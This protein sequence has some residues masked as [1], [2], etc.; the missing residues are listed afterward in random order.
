MTEFELSPQPL[1]RLCGADSIETALA[2]S[3]YAGGRLMIGSG[4]GALDFIK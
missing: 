2:R 3:R 1:F 4:G